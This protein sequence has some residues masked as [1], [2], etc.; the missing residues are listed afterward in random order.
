[1]HFLLQ[2]PGIISRIDNDLIGVAFNWVKSSTIGA[3]DEYNFETFY[4]FPVL[5]DVDMTLSYQSVFDPAFNTEFDQAS[6]FSLRL[7]T[8]F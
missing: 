4:R 8:N 5:P 3:R 1:V 6:A 7:Q 2:D